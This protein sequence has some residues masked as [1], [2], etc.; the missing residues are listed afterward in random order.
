MSKIFVKPKANTL[1]R[2]ENGEP[3]AEAG[4]E[5]ERSA[6][7]LRRERDGDVTLTD[8]AAITVE[9]PVVPAK[10]TKS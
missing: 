3:L 7:W 9:E 1:V 10:K 2:Q 5:V 6:Y 8:T 4:E